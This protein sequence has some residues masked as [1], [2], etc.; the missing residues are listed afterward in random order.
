VKEGTEEAEVK[1][2]RELGEKAVR[3]ASPVDEAPARW[4]PRAGA[5]SG[6]RR[7]TPFAEGAHVS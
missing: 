6:R 5:G 2:E 4:A 3:E 7:S 1:G